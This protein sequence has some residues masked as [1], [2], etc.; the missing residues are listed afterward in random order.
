MRMTLKAIVSLFIGLLLVGCGG[1]GGGGGDDGGGSI[2]SGSSLPACGIT[3]AMSSISTA[4]LERSGIEAPHA[5]RVYESGSGFAPEPKV[6]T[7]QVAAARVGLPTTTGVEPSNL[8]ELE[9]QKGQHIVLEFPDSSAAELHLYLLDELGI[10]LDATVGAVD[11]PTPGV[12]SLS[13]LV[14]KTGRYVVRVF[15]GRGHAPY[16]LR[17]YPG[18][19][20]AHEAHRGPRVSDEFVVH[21]VLVMTV[22]GAASA[23]SIRARELGLQEPRGRRAVAELWEVPAR[24][25]GHVLEVLRGW[26]PRSSEVPRWGAVGLRERYETLLI[27]KSLQA[28][29]EVATVSPNFILRTQHSLIPNDPRHPEQWFHMNIDLPEAWGISTGLPNDPQVVVA[30]VDTGVP[31]EHEDLQGRLLEVRDFVT[32]SPDDVDPPSDSSHGLHVAGIIGAATN[33]YKGVAGV[34][35]GT[36]MV[37]VRVLTEKGGTLS[38]LLAGIRHSADVL[39]ADVINLS[40][41]GPFP[42]TDFETFFRDIRDRGIFLLAASG[43]SAKGAIDFPAAC[44]AVFAVG[45][46]DLQKQRAHYSNYG[47]GLDLVAPG[48]AM[49]N[50]RSDGILST[51]AHESGYDFYQGTSM[52]TAVVSGVIA[53]AKA[54]DPNLT[55]ELFS[56]LL[57]SGQLTDPIGPGPPRW[58][59][60]TGWG[61]INALKTLQAVERRSAP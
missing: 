19:S 16:T 52:A 58:D 36:T 28:Q 22:P 10:S 47:D 13:L 1:G 17:L 21:Q 3:G 43:N 18:I 40:L 27:A 25:A 31:C 45:A 2:E 39:E 55:P 59:N 56:E 49:N 34:S 6:F 23:F 15:A 12:R 48:G 51:V 53:L 7:G 60:E 44:S 50:N 33:N 14:P 38:D 4:T 37:P 42:C 26:Q 20:P 35:W 57:Q 30:V 8:Y 41:G 46:T 24:Q 54:V 32:T 5:Q 29:L 9:L 61:Q 11:G